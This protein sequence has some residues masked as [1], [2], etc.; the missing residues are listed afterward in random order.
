M[1]PIT[2]LLFIVCALAV[3]S[4]LAVEEGTL[5]VK[6]TPDGAEVWLDDTYI[7]D[8]PIIDKKIK[9]GRY[10]VKLVDPI[11]KTS[12][13]EE[14]FVEAGKSAVLEKSMTGKFGSLKVASE[15]EAA[16]V[17][18]LTSLGKTPVSNDFMNPGKYRIEIRHPNARYT[19]VSQDIVVNR[20]ETVAI[21]KTL[22][23]S[24]PFDLKA[25]LRLG[26]GAGAA[27]GFVWAIVEQG[28]HKELDVE[29]SA[30]YSATST[31]AQ[32]DQWKKD[33]HSAAV[34]RTFGIIIG[35]ACVVGF[36]VVGFF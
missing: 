2:T 28:V 34:K 6:S 22:E 26:F 32:Q 4:A 19:P 23:R 3:R 36:E 18:L 30:K 14:V 15:P 10:S 24:N 17:Y 31:Q 12:V 21:N 33:S 16:N 20:G 5:T 25:L 9:A 13:V 7:G 1:K 29:A 11:Q 35:S 8:A 27:A